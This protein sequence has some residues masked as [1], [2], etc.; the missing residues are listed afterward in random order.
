MHTI[1]PIVKNTS[2]T[3]VSDTRARTPNAQNFRRLTDAER[4]ASLE[5]FMKRLR[6]QQ[7]LWV[8]GYGSL[9]WRPE[10]H[11]LERQPALLKGYHR[12]LCLWSRINRGTPERPGLVF[13]LDN[14]GSCKGMVYRIASKYIPET[15]D[16]LWK[17]EMPSAAYVPRH[18]ACH[19][20]NGATPALVFTVDRKKDGYV[21]GLNVPQLVNVIHQAHGSY[22]PC[23]EYV[24][25]TA[26]A[27]KAHNIHDGRLNELIQKLRKTSSSSP[28][29]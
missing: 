8:F 13:G 5:L 1:E 22:G 28:L 29:S 17:R 16:A 6:P 11:Y 27:L 20:P 4:Q 26:Q 23:I 21:R 7:D 3:S 2:H 19:T 24:L 14:G 25:E 18:L 12:S 9:V 15:L 10:F